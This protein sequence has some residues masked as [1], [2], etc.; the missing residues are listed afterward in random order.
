MTKQ[1]TA[2]LSDGIIRLVIFLYVTLAVLSFV[3]S[4]GFFTNFLQIRGADRALYDTLQDFNRTLFNYSF[5]VMMASF[6][7][8]VFDSQHG[9]H[10]GILNPII[11]MINS[12]LGFLLSVM[13]FS[14]LPNLKASY[15]GLNIDDIHLYFPKYELSTYMFDI[16]FGLAVAL[17][18]AAS[19]LM[20]RAIINLKSL[21]GAH[22][23]KLEN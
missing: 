5:Y 9:G 23:A 19:L 8:I 4:L 11:E 12:G 22:A 2:R 10:F 3:Y 16:G 20:I 18:I 21:G 1:Y 6:G 13:L 17:F 7:L 14:V 15:S